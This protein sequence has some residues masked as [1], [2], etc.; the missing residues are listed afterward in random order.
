MPLNAF[1]SKVKSNKL[2]SFS[3]TMAIINAA[4]L[5]KPTSFSNGLANDCLNNN[6]GTNEGSCKI[7]A[8][9]KLNQLNKAQTLSLFGD[10][11]YQDVLNDPEGSGHQNVRNFIQYGWEGIKFHE[12][13]TLRLK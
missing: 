3:D 13:D 10:F 9:A 8:F 5:Y 2:V 11:Y 1:L 7:F 4:Y 6:A 12:P